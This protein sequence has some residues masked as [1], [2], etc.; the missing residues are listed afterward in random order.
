MLRLQ[1]RPELIRQNKELAILA[2]KAG[3]ITDLEFAAFWNAGYLGLYLEVA[4]Q[5]RMRKGITD[6]QDIGDFSAHD[7][8]AANIF[9]G[10][11]GAVFGSQQGT[12][13]NS[14]SKECL[15]SCSKEWA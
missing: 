14:R 6:K 15:C 11:L 3:I 12:E 2:R 5:I 10:T 8:I 13:K 7:E 4:K 9:N 1:A